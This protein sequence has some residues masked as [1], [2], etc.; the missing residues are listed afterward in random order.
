[1]A[2]EDKII[3]T[4][5]HMELTDVLKQTV[6][7]KME[8]LFRHSDQIV[9]VRV[10]IG[11]SVK[12]NAKEEFIAKGHI[13]INGPDIHISETSED[14][15]KSIDK[16]VDKLDRQLRHKSNR[17]KEKLKHPHDVEIPAAIPKANGQ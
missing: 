7:E 8:R 15:Y 3:I 5:S 13:E 11:P 12:K 4:G 10:E 9:R 6:Q 1:M 2:N 16:M 17:D 14:L